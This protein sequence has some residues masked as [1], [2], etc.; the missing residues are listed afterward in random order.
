[1]P[2][3]LLLLVTL[4]GCCSSLHMDDNSAGGRAVDSV[5][6]GL[7]DMFPALDLGEEVQ[8]VSPTYSISQTDL[9]NSPSLSDPTPGQDNQPPLIP[10]LH[11]PLLYDNTRRAELTSRLRTIL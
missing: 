7:L 5:S 4:V 9:W 8:Q 3:L 1:M 10:E 11:P 6:G 2:I